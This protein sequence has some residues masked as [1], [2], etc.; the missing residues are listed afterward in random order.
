[1]SPTHHR[2]RWTLIVLNV[3]CIAYWLASYAAG[4]SGPPWIIMINLAGLVSLINSFR[5]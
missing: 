5:F 1:M 4:I 3:M 2:I